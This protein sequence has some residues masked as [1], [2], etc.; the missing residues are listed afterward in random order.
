MVLLVFRLRIGVAVRSLL[1]LCIVPKD[2]K[3]YMVV[4]LFHVGQN[5]VHGGVVIS[6]LCRLLPSS[7]NCKMI[8]VLI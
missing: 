1:Y 5:V 2:N 6:C 8:F 7:Y 3:V 4:G